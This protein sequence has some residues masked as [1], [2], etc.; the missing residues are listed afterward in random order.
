[1]LVTRPSY[2]RVLDT[3]LPWT[4]H[5][6]LIAEIGVRDSDGGPFRVAYHA[7]AVGT[8]KLVLAFTTVTACRVRSRVQLWPPTAIGDR[9]AADQPAFTAL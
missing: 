8:L 6:L 9:P 2:L 3:L 7:T 1:V 4:G 5:V